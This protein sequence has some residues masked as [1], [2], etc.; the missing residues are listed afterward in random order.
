MIAKLITEVTGETGSRALSEIE[1][2]LRHDVFHSTLDWQ[3][4]EE[5]ITGIKQA[6]EVFE[7]LKK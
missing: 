4:K 7:W 5:L 1:D 6:V 2:I 3:T